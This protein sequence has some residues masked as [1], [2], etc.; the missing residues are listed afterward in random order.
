MSRSRYTRYEIS[1]G[2]FV[3][4]GILAVLYL[5]VSLGGLSLFDDHRYNVNARFSSVAGLKTGDPVKIAGV[6]VGEV[7]GVTLENYQANLVLRID[8]TVKLPTDTIA[9]IQSAGLL[10]DSYVSLS[11]GANDEELAEGGK[12]AR[13]EPAVSLTELIAKYA[14]GSPVDDEKAPDKEEKTSAEDN[15]D[16]T[17]TTEK[18]EKTEGEQDGKSEESPFAN[19]FD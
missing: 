14:F 12:I 6:T 10:G 4:V 2:A 17:D 11:P 18:T 19:P 15:K 9:S 5:S 13:T 7:G 16:S 1:V 8:Q 3:L